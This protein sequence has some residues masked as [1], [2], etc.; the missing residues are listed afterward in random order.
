MLRCFKSVNWGLTRRV[1][2]ISAVRVPRL[3]RVLVVIGGG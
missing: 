3:R 2:K 1:R